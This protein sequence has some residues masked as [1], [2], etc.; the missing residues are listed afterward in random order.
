MSGRTAV[1]LTNGGHINLPGNRELIEDIFMRQ[2]GL[3]VEVI[4]DPT[5]VTRARLE[6]PDILLDYSG[7]PKIL[8]TDE[9]LDAL[10]A[11][12]EAGKP[13]LAMHAASLPV[14]AQ[15]TYIR[16]NEG[17]WPAQAAPNEHINAAQIRYLSMLGSAFLTH[18][19]V[20]SFGVQILD[21]HHPVTR[22]IA[23]FDIEDELYEIVGDMNQL[24]VLVKGEEDR[25]LAYVKK[26]GQGTV[27]Y[28][29]L[30]HG[31]TALANPN[32]QRIYV[33]AAHWLLQGA[34]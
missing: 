3:D 1:L 23:N 14:R 5:E 24:H 6:H 8:A 9:Q 33:Q 32:L 16:E 12:V 13:Y 34:S 21:Q 7:D 26:H 17:A 31:A 11:T 30:G 15:M 29:A 20:R 28:V 25:P 19:P 18:P 27:V 10:I 22:G 4:H 2:A